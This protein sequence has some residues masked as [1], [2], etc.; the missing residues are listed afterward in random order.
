MLVAFD[1]WGLFAFWTVV[2]VLT[3]VYIL[4][5][6]PETSGRSLETMDELFEQP[7][8]K[9]GMASN[10]PIPGDLCNPQR[11]EISEIEQV[12]AMPITS[13]S[14]DTEA[15]LEKKSVNRQKGD[16]VDA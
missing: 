2:S 16:T 15:N 3:I 6:I 8:W 4:L 12:A 9:I 11:H 10:R 1:R 5:F 14:I 13:K 7:W